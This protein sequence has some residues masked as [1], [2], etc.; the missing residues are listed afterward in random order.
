VSV[1][2]LEVDNLRKEPLSGFYNKEIGSRKLLWTPSALR[3]GRHTV[4]AVYKVCDDCNSVR[5]ERYVSDD[6]LD[7]PPFPAPVYRSKTAPLDYDTKGNWIGKYG[8]LGYR[9]Y[10]FN[11]NATDLS[12][13][14]GWI[15][16]G[17]WS[18]HSPGKNLFNGTG[19]YDRYLQDPN[20]T[21]KKALGGN[22]LKNADGSQ[23]IVVNVAVNSEAPEYTLSLYLVA[24]DSSTVNA[25]RVM[26]LVRLNVFAKDTVIRSFQDGVYWSVKVPQKVSVRVRYMGIYGGLRLS[27]V[28]LD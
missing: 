17:F 11:A 15:D 7:V 12:S 5:K 6:P 24:D 10:G 25:I 20:D 26:D 9:L 22:Y 3:P 13:L 8:S 18:G 16:I 19:Y 1:D 27:A 28:F 2:G 23:G 21:Q 4:K 14:P